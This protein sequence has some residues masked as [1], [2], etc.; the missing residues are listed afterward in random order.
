MF[1]NLLYPILFEQF[2]SLLDLF[3]NCSVSN[4]IHP[5]KAI[6]FCGSLGKIMNFITLNFFKILT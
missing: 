1:Y 2:D 6:T 3:L 4:K 5:L